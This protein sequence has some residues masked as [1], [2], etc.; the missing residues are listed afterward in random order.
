MTLILEM[1]NA[2]ESNL[3]ADALLSAKKKGLIVK[4]NSFRA[5]WCIMM[6]YG[7]TYNAKTDADMREYVRNY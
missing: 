5:G 3:N 4:R 1:T 6:P 7:G 2:F